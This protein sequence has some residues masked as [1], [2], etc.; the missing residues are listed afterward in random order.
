MSEHGRAMDRRAHLHD[1]LDRVIDAVRVRDGRS[2]RA[3]N[4]PYSGG[5]LTPAKE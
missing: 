4:G 1:A 5:P 2:I 3:M